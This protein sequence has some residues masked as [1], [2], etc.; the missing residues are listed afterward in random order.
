MAKKQAVEEVPEV[1]PVTVT[2]PINI[3]GVGYNAGDEVMLTAEEVETLTAVGAPIEG[4]EPLDGEAIQAKHDE[5]VE[6]L[7]ARLEADAEAEK[8]AK[9]EEEY[10]EEEEPA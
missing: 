3:K 1:Q 2:G 10:D 8:K 4:V 5:G 7:K 6:A 9:E